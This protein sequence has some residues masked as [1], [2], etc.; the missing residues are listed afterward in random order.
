[1]SSPEN[2]GTSLKNKI[3]HELAE[4]WI[5]ACYLALVFA[6][7]TEYRRLILAAHEITYTNY[8]VAVIE[9]LI[10]A[11]VVL[12]GDAIHLGRRLE[13]NMVIFAAFIPFFAFKELER[14]LGGSNN[15][16]ALFFLRRADRGAEKERIDT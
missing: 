10:L 8:W 4:Y 7:F 2:K 12:I 5:T 13:D 3:F 16:R 9:A 14:V 6:T 11:K 15:I 1:M